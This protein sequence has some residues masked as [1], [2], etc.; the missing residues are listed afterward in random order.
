[1]KSIIYN[2]PVISA[3]L[4]NLFSLFL[5]LY[6]YSFFGFILT[7]MPLTGFLNGKII[8]NGTDMNN[9]KKILIIVSLLM[10]IGI[11]LFSIYNMI[12]NKFIN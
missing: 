5:C 8:V 1:M 10:M 7:I 3:I 6:I 2:N 12:I 9:K 11:I 4:L